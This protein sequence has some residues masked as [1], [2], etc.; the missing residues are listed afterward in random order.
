MHRLWTVLVLLLVGYAVLVGLVWALQRRMLY[1]PMGSLPSAGSVLPGAQ[2]VEFTTEDELRLR[3]WLLPPRA[4]PNGA[5]VLI[6]NGNAGNRAMRAPIAA[7]FADAGY[8]AMLLDYRGYGGNP[9]SPTEDGLIADGVAATRYLA[10][11]GDVDPERIVYYGES[12]GSGVALGVALQEP[13]AAMVL[14]S[15]FVSMV[16]LAG[17]HYPFLPARWLLKDR[18]QAAEW[19]ARID[20]P[21]LV[22]AGEAD[23]VVPYGQS[24]RLYDAAGMRVKRFVSVPRA[25]HNDRAMIGPGVMAQTMRFLREEAGVLRREITTT[26]TAEER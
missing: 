3:A 12:L 9:G 6:F 14:R 22:V 19:L 4:R 25:D 5:T 1:F 26:G 18:Y 7:A 10:A 17:L 13:P 20:C 11:R 24:R 16:D 21:L 15:P 23:R 8:T 2:E